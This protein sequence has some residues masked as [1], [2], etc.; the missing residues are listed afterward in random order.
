MTWNDVIGLTLLAVGG[1]GL[2]Y[3]WRAIWNLEA[4]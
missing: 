4:P 1:V 2:V 3:N